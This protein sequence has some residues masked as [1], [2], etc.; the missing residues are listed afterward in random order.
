[1]KT[2]VSPKTVLNLVENVL[3][4]KR[5]ATKV[6]QGI[7]LKKSKAEIFIVLGQ[8]KAITIFVKGRTEL[9]LEAT[10]HEDMDDAIYQAKDYL[11]R[12]YEI[13]DE[14]AKR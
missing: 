14:V 10:R 2:Q 6:M 7:Y 12:I 9:F 4:S 13:L 8:H 3:L 1:M 11:K 5:N